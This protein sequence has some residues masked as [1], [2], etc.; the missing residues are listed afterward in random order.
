MKERGPSA[1]KSGSESNIEVTLIEVVS[2]DQ[3]GLNPGFSRSLV[4]SGS[5]LI[6]ARS[7]LHAIQFLETG[8]SRAIALARSSPLIS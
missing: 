6:D 7:A 1:R 5:F 2:N 8:V 3:E 4:Q